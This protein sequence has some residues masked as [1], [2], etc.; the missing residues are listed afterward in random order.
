MRI[1]F[2]TTSVKGSRIH[3]TV[4]P[5]LIFGF[6]EKNFDKNH[7]QSMFPVR[8]VLELKQTHSNLIRFDSQAEA[9]MEGDGIILDRPKTMA[10]IKTADC[11]PLFFWDSTYSTGG[12]IHVGWRGLWKGIENKLLELL[13]ILS[14]SSKE[15]YFFLG[16]S[17]ERD[18]YEV[19][20]NMLEVF[21]DKS[22]NQLIFFP[23]HLLSGTKYLMDIKKGLTLSLERAGI[24][25]TKIIDSGIC[26]YCKE[27][28]PSHRRDQKSGRIYNFLFFKEI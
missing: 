4:S 21:A 10:I 18:C 12:V 17:I 8:R 28:F 11:I 5:R 16:P 15:L 2:K 13:S 9:G 26:N 14:I 25:K 23:H 6:T 22:Y 20:Q 3:Y 19:D 1:E 7:L 27:E 24:S